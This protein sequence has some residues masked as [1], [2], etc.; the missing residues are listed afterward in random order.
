MGYFF[1][2]GMKDLTKKPTA[3]QT[4]YM[5][6]VAEIKRKFKNISKRGYVP[7]DNVYK[8][9]IKIKSRNIR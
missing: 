6:L 1:Y 7:L 4:A 3:N 8:D 9:D 5:E 2:K